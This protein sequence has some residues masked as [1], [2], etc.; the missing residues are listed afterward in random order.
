VE[1]LRAENACLKKWR[2]L[3]EQRIARERAGAIRE[4]RPSHRLA[5]LLEAAGMARSIFYYHLHTSAAGQICP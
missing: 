1:R 2:V 3:V 5:L 4:L